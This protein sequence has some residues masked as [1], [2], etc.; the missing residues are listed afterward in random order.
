M[1]D[2]KNKPNLKWWNNG[3]IGLAILVVVYAILFIVGKN[4]IQQEPDPVYD[5]LELSEWTEVISNYDALR[6]YDSTFYALHNKAPKVLRI[7][8]QEL[9]PILVRWLDARDTVPQ[10]VYFFT[11]SMFDRGDVRYLQDDYGARSK[12]L[13]AVKVIQALSVRDPL[14]IAA[15]ERNLGHYRTQNDPKHGKGIDPLAEIA[16]KELRRLKGN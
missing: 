2:A 12:H 16:E 9:T 11:I 10:M 6:N 1:S 3:W 8:Q 5:G 4:S 14:L 7:H 15:L 13:R